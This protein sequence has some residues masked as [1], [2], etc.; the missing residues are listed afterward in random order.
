[1]E[2]AKQIS[3]NSKSSFYYTFALLPKDKREAMDVVYSFCRLTDDIVD[4]QTYSAEAKEQKLHEWKND[5]TKSLQGKAEIPLFM[6]LKECIDKFKIPHKPFYDLID[7]VELDLTKNRYANFNELKDYCY[8]VASTVGLMTIPI[9]GYKNPKTIDFAI[10]LGIALQL[11]NIIRDIKVDAENNRI[12]LPQDE[13]VKFNYSENELLKNNYD[14]NFI[15]L[16]Q[17]QTDRAREFY[18]IADNNLTKKDKA[19]MFTAKSMEYIYCRL[20]DIIEQEKFNVFDKRIRVSNFNKMLLA[21]AVY[22][23]YKIF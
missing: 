14:E 21:L 2:T 3:K 4:N 7:G 5:F 9:F 1:M 19:S 6:E 12:Y 15:E 11:T 17:F 16:M 8:K 22:I 10:N 18:K 23:K 13:L 20:L